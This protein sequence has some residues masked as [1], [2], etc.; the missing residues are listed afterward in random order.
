MTRSLAI[1]F[2]LTVTLAIMAALGFM[3]RELGWQFAGGFLVATIFW[4]VTH[5]LSKGYWFTG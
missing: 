1:L 4:E 3:F 5:R 2:V